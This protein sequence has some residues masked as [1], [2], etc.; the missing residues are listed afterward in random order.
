MRIGKVN[1]IGEL[2]NTLQ[3]LVSS[4]AER[5]VEEVSVA[6]R[7]L[8]A[9]DTYGAVNAGIHAVDAASGDML[10]TADWQEWVHDRMATAAGRTDVV[11]MAYAALDSVAGRDI[12]GEGRSL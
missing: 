5:R 9:L 11:R 4:T 12:R 2:R 8:V 3:M 1:D 7:K 6:L 10:A